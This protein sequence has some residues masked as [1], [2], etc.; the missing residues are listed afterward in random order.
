VTCGVWNRTRLKSLELLNEAGGDE[1]LR[2]NL[3]RSDYRTTCNFLVFLEVATSK[4]PNLF[5]GYLLKHF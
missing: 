3:S 2:E 4:S 5:F 1:L